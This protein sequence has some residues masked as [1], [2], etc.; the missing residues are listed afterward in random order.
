MQKQREDMT[1]HLRNKIGN[2]MLEYFKLT[3]ITNATK[4][5]G[6]NII[7]MLSKKKDKEKQDGTD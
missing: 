1:Q 4:E 2:K 7:V 6:V 3:D 5:D